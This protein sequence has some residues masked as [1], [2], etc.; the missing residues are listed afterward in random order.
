[1]TRNLAIILAMGLVASGSMAL[2]A[3]PSRSGLYE[4]VRVSDETG[5]EG[6]FR[7]RVNDGPAPTVDFEL[8][9]GA[10][11]GMRRFPAR[12][13]GDRLNFIYVEQD[14]DSSGKPVPE[15]RANVEARFVPNGLK[16][17]IDFADYPGDDHGPFTL[18]RRVKARR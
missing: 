7:I 1:M 11:L 15:T 10:C 8:C 5:D 14:V 9:E 4:N 18:A 12:I 17:R 6:G 2:A 3:S 16:L 13:E